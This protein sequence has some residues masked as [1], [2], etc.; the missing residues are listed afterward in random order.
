MSQR[1]LTCHRPLPASSPVGK[2]PQCH[3]YRLEPPSRIVPVFFRNFV[4][5]AENTNLN[6]LQSVDASFEGW[7]SQVAAN[8]I[9]LT[10]SLTGTWISRN[11]ANRQ[12]EVV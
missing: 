2:R 10:L 6:K 9:A 8:G 4:F 3:P 1:R 7:D 12:I 5:G 11:S